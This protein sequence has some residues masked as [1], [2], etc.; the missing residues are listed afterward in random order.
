MPL[1]LAKL[2][3]DMQSPDPV[4]QGPA[5]KEAARVTNLLTSEA[6]K[7]LATSSAPVAVADQL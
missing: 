1:D 2:V 3:A 4:T 6:V 5:L 7:A